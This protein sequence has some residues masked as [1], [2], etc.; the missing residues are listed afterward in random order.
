MTAHI[1]HL[2]RLTKVEG[3]KNPLKELRSQGK[4]QIKCIETNLFLQPSL[5]SW[6]M[7]KLLINHLQAYSHRARRIPRGTRSLNHP[8]M[9]TKY[10]P[11][12]TKMCRHLMKR[13]KKGTNLPCLCHCS[14]SFLARVKMI[15]S[16][17]NT[18]K[19]WN[20]ENTEKILKLVVPK[21]LKIRATCRLTSNWTRI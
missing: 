16:K 9:S 4:K 15:H 7:I 3:W 2:L 6:N 13:T 12:I 5:I 8:Y 17:K 20:T 10:L 18:Q 19:Y 11:L 14:S 1:R 21:I